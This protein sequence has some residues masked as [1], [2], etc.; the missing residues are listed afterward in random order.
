MQHVEWPLRALIG[1]GLVCLFT[2]LKI[3]Q[4]RRNEIR[5]RHCQRFSLLGGIAKH[6]IVNILGAQTCAPDAIVRPM[7]ETEWRFF[8]NRRVRTNCTLE[9]SWPVSIC[10][11]LPTQ[12]LRPEP[13]LFLWTAKGEQIH[14]LLLCL[15]LSL[16]DH[17]FEDARLRL[18]RA[19]TR[20]FLSRG[21]KRAASSRVFARAS[22]RSVE[23]VFQSSA[24]W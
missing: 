23:N 15:S 17:F 19:S 21:T 11:P 13:T 18:K 7:R 24:R 6:L 12:G 10:I 5:H 9:Y 3:P 1:K 20:G 2:M 22:E 4:I 8:R 14:S 16:V